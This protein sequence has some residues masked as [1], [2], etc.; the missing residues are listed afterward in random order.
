MR[1]HSWR[2]RVEHRFIARQ[3]SKLVLRQQRRF[4][5]LSLTRDGNADEI[6][7]RH[8]ELR[9][10]PRAREVPRPHFLVDE[11]LE[12]VG[13]GAARGPVDPDE[14]D[15]AV[16]AADGREGEDGEAGDQQRRLAEVLLRDLALL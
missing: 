2:K 15:V 16:V 10:A 8:G 3:E 12:R 6:R 4:F 9:E 7:Q 11:H 13:V 5:F 1:G 14:H